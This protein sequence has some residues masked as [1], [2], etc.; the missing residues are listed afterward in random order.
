MAAGLTPAESGLELEPV[1]LVVE[2][3]RQNYE[4]QRLD[5]QVLEYREFRESHIMEGQ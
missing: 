3:S 2:W 4:R 5:E 1:Q